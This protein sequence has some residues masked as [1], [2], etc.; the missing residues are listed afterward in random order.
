MKAFV[1]KLGPA[2]ERFLEFKHALGIKYQACEVHLRELD[3]YNLIHGNSDILT[4]EVAEGWALEHA[5]KS[6][7]QDRSWIPPIRE[8]GRFLISTG[9]TSAYVLDN[10]FIVRQYHAEVYLMTED[11]IRRFFDECDRCAP[12]PNYPGRIYVYPALY[13]FMYCCGVRSAEARN[14]KCK[15]VNLDEG[16][17][18]IL[19]A[20]AHRDRRLFL[21]DELIHY[22][23]KYNS[24]IQKV[25]PDREYFF[26][27]G[28]GGICSACALAVNFRNIWKSAGLRYD[29]KV[30][31]RAYDFRHHF[32]CRNI[33]RWSS[34]GK[35]VHAML[36]YLM[37]Y[38]G[39]SSLES[40][41]YYVHLFPD[42]FPKYRELT[43]ATE[44]LIP[45]V[46]DNEV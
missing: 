42:Y 18:D 2:M 17:A 1:S 30:K 7:T 33:M 11:E 19:W 38:M 22:L 28:Y 10:K 39:H 45:E 21:S 26:P 25:F 40:T 8:F 4:K 27:G 37:R 29:G 36:P 46:D 14:L 5:G 35:D 31:P 24:A 20:K 6:T 43:S 15:D 32:A 13:R 23:Q 34:E 3:R 16:Y 41:Y 12:H 9:D 44:N